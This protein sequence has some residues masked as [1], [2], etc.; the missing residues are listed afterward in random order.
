MEKKSTLVV[1]DEKNIR[2]T[3]SETLELLEIPVHTAVNGEEALQKLRQGRFGLVFLDLRMPGM[4]GME[5]L[6][7]I[8]KEWPGL[9]VIVITAYGTIESA[10][11]AM[12]IGAVDFVQ[13][14]FSH[15]EI[16]ELA[17]SVLGREQEDEYNVVDY[18]SLIERVRRLIAEQDITAASEMARKAIA[19]DPTQPEAYNLLGA[20]LETD[21]DRLG[22]QKFYRAAID[23]DP[24]FK[25]AWAN[26]DRTTSSLKK[27]GEIDLGPEE[28]E[29]DT[30][31]ESADGNSNEE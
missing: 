14:P 9:P 19:M 22:A 10:V 8:V 3:I 29:K 13:K 23:M 2:L 6:R 18:R 30:N 12:K 15:D 27:L 4:D 28:T 16:R 5:V 1:D 20:L 24:T 11:E 31:N 21:G 26:L 25:S 7:Q 17:A